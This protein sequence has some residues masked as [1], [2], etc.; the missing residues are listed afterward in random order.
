MTSY[1]ASN[2]IS[3]L[4]LNPLSQMLQ[5]MQPLPLCLPLLSLTRN[6]AGVVN[7]A[8]R[9]ACGH[10]H[11]FNVNRIQVI[12]RLF[13]YYSKAYICLANF[14]NQPWLVLC[15][16]STFHSNHLE[17]CSFP[18]GSWLVSSKGALLQ[19]SCSARGSLAFSSFHLQLGNR[20]CRS[21]GGDL[22]V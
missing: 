18:V 3:N 1:E 9:R 10:G 13:A 2:L 16:L 5:Q 17:H 4:L 20:L 14:W 12:P 15:T 6:Y 8:Q 21:N 7:I 11:E 22:V 19:N